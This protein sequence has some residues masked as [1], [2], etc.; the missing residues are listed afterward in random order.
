MS[1]RLALLHDLP[2]GAIETLVDEQNQPLFKGANL[3]KYLDIVDQ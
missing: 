1:S 3:G 2:A